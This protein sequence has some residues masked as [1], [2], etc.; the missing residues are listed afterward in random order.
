MIIEYSGDAYDSFIGALQRMEGY[1]MGVTSGADVTNDYE[2][3]EAGQGGLVLRRYSEAEGKAVGEA[4]TIALI[5]VERV[6]VY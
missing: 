3:V 5:D 1:V 6:Y 2:L 4:V